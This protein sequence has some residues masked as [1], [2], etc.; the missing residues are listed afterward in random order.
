MNKEETPKGQTD[1][2]G[3]ELETGSE[4]NSAVEKQGDDAAAGIPRGSD[5]AKQEHEHEKDHDNGE[6]QG[7]P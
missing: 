4:G 3:N 6:L 7:A 2:I 1:E 5:A